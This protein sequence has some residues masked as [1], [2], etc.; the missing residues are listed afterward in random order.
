MNPFS[1]IK[2]GFN[3]LYMT[4]RDNMEKNDYVKSIELYGDYYY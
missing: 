2:L 1:V 3:L 4:K